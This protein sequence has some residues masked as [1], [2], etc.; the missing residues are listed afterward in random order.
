MVCPLCRSTALVQIG[1]TLRE[2]Q[3]TM[4]SCSSCD[5]R[6]WEKDGQRVALP[7]VLELAARR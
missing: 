6:W 5:T 7:S 3:V 2:Q 4:H 1:L